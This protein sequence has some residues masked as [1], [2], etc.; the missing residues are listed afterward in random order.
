MPRTIMCTSF[1]IKMSKVKFT[2][3]I[4]VETETVLSTEREGIQTSELVR[5]W[6]MRYQLPRPSIT[7]CEVRLLNLLHA[8]LSHPAATQL[9]ITDFGSVQNANIHMCTYA[10]SVLYGIPAKYISCLQRTQNTLARVV[11]GNRTPGSHLATLSKLHQFTIALN[12]KCHN[13]PLYTRCN[14]SKFSLAAP[15][16][17]NSLPSHVRSC[18]TLTTFRRHLKSHFSAH[19]SLPSDPSQ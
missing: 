13:D 7:A 5:Q 6:S 14:I 3:P 9:Y 16:I 15:T 17:W 10:N 8:C 2:R 4:T 18:E 11:A 1:K 12:S 19:L